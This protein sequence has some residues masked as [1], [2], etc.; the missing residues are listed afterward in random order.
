MG[1]YLFLL[2]LGF[3]AHSPL[4]VAQGLGS[5]VGR[6]TDPSGAAVASAKVPATEE[7]TGF[8]RAAT[9]DTEGLY[10]IP[11]LHPAT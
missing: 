7:G 5:I 6:V 8:S 1:K 3:L 10:I 4:S 9:S 2:L 11:S